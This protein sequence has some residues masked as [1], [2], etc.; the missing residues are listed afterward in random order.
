MEQEE[1]IH[2]VDLQEKIPVKEEAIK[3]EEPFVV[4]DKKEETPVKNADVEMTVEAINQEDINP[5]DGALGEYDPTLDLPKFRYPPLSLM[6]DY[7]QGENTVTNEELISNK[8]RIVE[9]LGNYN[10]KIDKIKATIGPTVTLY[11]IVP[12]PGIRIS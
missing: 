2:E 11:E 1:T 3:E 10:I 7:D 4:M 6:K 5:D 12:A 9:T 8:N